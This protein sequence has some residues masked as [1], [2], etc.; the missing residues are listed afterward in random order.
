M[1][2]I[3]CPDFW[4]ISTVFIALTIIFLTL[5]GTYSII[6]LSDIWSKKISDRTIKRIYIFLLLGFIS[7]TASITIDILGYKIFYGS[8]DLRYSLS[9]KISICWV[10]YLIYIHI[11]KFIPQKYNWFPGINLIVILGAS[12]FCFFYK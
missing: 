1:D 12:V 3:T 11:V 10:T 6:G 8:F 9:E 2:T 5:S 7:F 4:T